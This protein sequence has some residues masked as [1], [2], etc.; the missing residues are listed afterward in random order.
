MLPCVPLIVCPS[1]YH[2][3]RL[4]VFDALNEREPTLVGQILINRTDTPTEDA[5]NGHALCRRFA[6]HGRSPADNKVR[7]PKQI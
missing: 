2:D 1:L 6:V 3:L 4:N 7:E 5:I